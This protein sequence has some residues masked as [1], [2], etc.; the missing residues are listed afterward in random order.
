M[1]KNFGSFRDPSGYVYEADGKIFRS[2]AEGYAPDYECFTASGLADHL[3]QKKW[4]PDFHES[5]REIPGA[6]KVLE[7][8][9]LPWISYPYEWCFQQLKEAALLTLKIQ[10][11]AL[12]HGMT[13]KDASAYNIQLHRGRLVFIDLQ[14]FARYEEGRPWVAYR[15]F[16]M[17]FLGPLLLMAKKDIRFSHLLRDYV[18]GLPVD[19]VSR[20]LPWRTRF[21]P[22]CLIHI[23]WHAKLLKKYADTHGDTETHAQQQKSARMPLASQVKFI[24]SLRELVQGLRVP[25]LATEWGDYY[26]DTN[27]TSAAFLAKQRLIQ[28]LCERFQPKSVCDLG[29]NCGEFSRQVPASVPTVISADID[30]VAV[31]KNYVQVRKNK[32]RNIYPVLLDLCNPSPGIGWMNAERESFLAR[33]KCDLAMGLAL[34]HHLCIGNN[35]P[36]DYVASLFHTLAPV[37][38]VEFVPK[39]DSQVDRL[40]SS[41]EDI[42]PDY[43]LENCVAAFSRLYPNC[44]THPVEDSQR[45]VVVFWK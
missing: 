37:A 13:L 7:V 39:G 1:K 12:A 41:R 10:L 28:Q 44:E 17:H 27:Y 4:V 30:P 29:A 35:L 31:D 8:E 6:W 36:L 2:L 34:V 16:V 20:N 33:A 18:D 25:E 19:F 32:D 22:S 26:Q 23:H 45:T 11:A 21:S 5:D 14:S 42:F 43:T 24:E 40:L 3:K 9:R 15:Q 38:V